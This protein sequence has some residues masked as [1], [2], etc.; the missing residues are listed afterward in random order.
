MVLG[1]WAVFGYDSERMDLLTF[2]DRGPEMFKVV[3]FE[4]RYF[5]DVNI[6]KNKFLIRKSR[7]L[8]S[9]GREEPNQQ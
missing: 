7:K 6:L 9:R 1:I 2:S 4:K 8:Q 3:P 5:K